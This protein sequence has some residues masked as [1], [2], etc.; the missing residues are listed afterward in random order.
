MVTLYSRRIYAMSTLE[1][2]AAGIPP[3]II[4]TSSDI[5]APPNIA[6][7]GNATLVINEFGPSI[8]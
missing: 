1:A 3:A 5:V 6:D 4:E 2:S 8:N 7:A